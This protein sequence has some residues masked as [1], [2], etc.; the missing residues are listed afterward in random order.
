MDGTIG[1]S[2]Q[3]IIPVKRLGLFTLILVY[4]FLQIDRALASFHLMVTS[5][6]LLAVFLSIVCFAAIRGKPTMKT[7]KISNLG[8]ES[9]ADKEPLA[10]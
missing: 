6:V 8:R 3:K 5:A 7:I 1:K 10:P 4:H 2:K 9:A